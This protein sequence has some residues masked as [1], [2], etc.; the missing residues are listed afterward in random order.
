MTVSGPSGQA[1][2]AND[3][4]WSIRSVPNL[5]WLLGGWGACTITSST[6]ASVVNF[7]SLV[8]DSSWSGKSPSTNIYVCMII[9]ESLSLAQ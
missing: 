2:I 3:N 7:V 1:A 8:S 6:K 5:Y 9:Y 4:E